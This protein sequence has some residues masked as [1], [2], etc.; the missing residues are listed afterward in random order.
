MMRNVKFVLVAVAAAA[1][2]LALSSPVRAAETWEIDPV[3]TEVL[4]AV[5]H[6]GVSTQYGRFNDL[7]GKIVLDEEN[8]ENSSIE[9]EIKTA[10]VD[11]GDEKRDQHLRSPDFFNAKQFPVIRF[12]STGIE[13]T[14]ES[15]Y[16]ISGELTMHGTTK[17][18]TVTFE[19]LGTTTTPKKETVT[20]GTTSFTVERSDFGVDY[21]V[22][23]VGDEVELM[24]SVEAIKQ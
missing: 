23:P 2:A 11:T 12:V 20:G 24:I 4:F 1:S 13:K 7:S 5:S 14:G 3:H 8:P 15:A 19:R 9:L 10:S 22:G 21:L 18:L 6:L 17:P 16:E